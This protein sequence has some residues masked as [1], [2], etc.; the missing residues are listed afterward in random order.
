MRF[1]QTV[2]V[3]IYRRRGVVLGV[4]S[5]A[6]AGC[7]GSRRRVDITAAAGSLNTAIAS[8][9]GFVAGR[10]LVQDSFGTGQVI[11]GSL[12]VT[13]TDIEGV[14]DQLNQILRTVV[15]EWAKI[16]HASKSSV[17]ID[18]TSRRDPA[19]RVSTPEAV[20]S[21]EVT[22]DTDQLVTEFGR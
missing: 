3:G 9:P 4:V 11:S 18:A 2:R 21:T 16:P 10:L 17:R 13:A 20:G 15:T 19:V 7:G 1:G 6:L 12:S 8:V 22:V 5:L 14:A